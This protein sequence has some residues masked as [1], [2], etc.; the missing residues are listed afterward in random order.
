MSDSGLPLPFPR[1]F[2]CEHTQSKHRVLALVSD[3][4]GTAYLQA[5]L[6]G[7]DG[8]LARRAAHALNAAL[9]KGP[10]SSVHSTCGDVAAEL[11]RAPAASL[12]QTVLASG[13]PLRCVARN[14]D[15]EQP[16]S[17]ARAPA[18]GY[19][20]RRARWSRVT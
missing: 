19:G 14:R 3:D 9:G 17:L 7:A 13:T 6:S 5:V 20:V 10:G 15:L 1:Q 4:N 12:R 2:R 16:D 8:K 18:C 11:P